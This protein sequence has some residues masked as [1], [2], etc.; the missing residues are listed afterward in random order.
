MANSNEVKP[1]T[2]EMVLGKLD[3]L[4]AML[5]SV[6]STGGVEAISH[7]RTLAEGVALMRTHWEKNVVRRKETIRDLM[8]QVLGPDYFE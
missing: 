5:K 4:S 2:P 7:W 1:A 6:E 8:M 3:E